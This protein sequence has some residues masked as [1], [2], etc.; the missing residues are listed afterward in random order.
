MPSTGAKKSKLN[1]KNRKPVLF[2][3]RLLIDVK[4]YKIKIM[5]FLQGV[6]AGMVR[7]IALDPAYIIRSIY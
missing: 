6:K 3:M 2:F 4:E 5:G 7:R 1:P